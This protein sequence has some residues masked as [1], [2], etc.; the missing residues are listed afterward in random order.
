MSL[1]PPQLYYRY[2]LE[3][4]LDSLDIPYANLH[5]AGNDAHFTLRAILMIVVRDAQRQHQD[6]DDSLFRVLEAVAR[7]PRPLVP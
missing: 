2:S 1:L 4:L 7:A 6:I 5:A 3:K